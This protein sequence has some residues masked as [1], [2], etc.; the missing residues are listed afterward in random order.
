MSCTATCRFRFIGD[1]APLSGT[2]DLRSQG[3]HLDPEIEIDGAVMCL[4]DLSRTDRRDW[5]AHLGAIPPELRRTVLV[6]G[7]EE[8]TDRASMLERGFGD[9]VSRRITVTEFTARALRVHAACSWLPRRRDIGELSL[10]LLAREAFGKGKP[11]NLNP[12]EFALLWRLA[13][14]PDQPVTKAEII[15]DVWRMGFMPATNSIAVHMSRLRRKL[16]FVGM[17][18]IVETAASGGYCL[19]TQGPIR[20]LAASM[21]P[22]R[23]LTGYP[24]GQ[25]AGS[26]SPIFQFSR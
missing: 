4:L 3:W 18:S 9:A 1:A 11:L 23:R 7:I 25:A 6:I 24:A 22:Q 13:D 21:N 12:R 26:S 15:R 5:E 2:F 16:A 20:S 14:K 10:D 8:G 19:R 17:E